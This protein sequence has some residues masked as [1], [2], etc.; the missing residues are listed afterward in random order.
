MTIQHIDPN[1]IDPN[2]YQPTTRIV[3]TPEQLADLESVK[4]IGF[5]FTP[6]ARPYKTGRFQMNVGWRRR[7]AWLL[8]RP[9]EPM[10]LDVQDLTDEQMFDQSAI[11]NGQRADL[12]AI[13][14]AHLLQRAITEFGMTQGKAGKLLSLGQAA[15]SNLLRLLQLPDGV[16]AHINERRIPER[17]ARQL[18]PIARIAPTHIS[19]IADKIA[20]SPDDE[21]ESLADDEIWTLLIAKGKPIG[22]LPWPSGWKLAAAVKIEGQTENPPACQDCP[23]RIIANRKPFCARPV[24]FQIKLAAWTVRELERLSKKLG[25]PIAGKGEQAV[26]VALDYNN[27]DRARKL[28]ESKS[29]AELFRLMPSDDHLYYHEHVLGSNAV[30]LAA[31][32]PKILERKTG[33]PVPVKKAN[34]IPEQKRKRE[35]AEERKR[36]QRRKEKSRLRKDKADIFWL[37]AHTAE[38]VAPTL[39][40]SGG[41]LEFAEDIIDN[42]FYSLHADWPEMKD[43]KND[44]HRETGAKGKA[45]EPILRQSIIISEANRELSAFS[46]EEQFSW[47]RARN[48]IEEL[49]VNTLK[50]QLPAGWDQPPIHQTPSNCW[51]CGTFTSMDHITKIDESKGWQTTA[52]GRVTCSDACRQAKAKIK[53]AQRG[54]K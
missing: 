32:D 50:L 23:A 10:P 6:I 9:G 24:C 14:K 42:R 34:E 13:E 46:P 11:E 2:P 28:L 31:F 8:F 29:R 7:C 52:D 37:V 35:A 53:T 3:F 16:Q 38:V 15:V 22:S 48:K 51:V 1:L 33:E 54:K 21:K 30:A 26:R 49:I 44:L 20:Q 12:S 25:I 5:I 43:L 17:I 45:R 36:E 19:K 41:I 47:P 27:D 40:I 39:V 4:E 18:V